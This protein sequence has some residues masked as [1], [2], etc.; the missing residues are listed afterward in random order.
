MRAPTLHRLPSPALW[1]PL[2][3]CIPRVAPGTPNPKQQPGA[4]LPG[5]IASPHRSDP[6]APPC[7]PSWPLSRTRLAG[8]GG[9]VWPR[10]L[11]NWGWSVGLGPPPLPPHLTPFPD[12]PPLCSEFVAVE[13]AT[14]LVGGAGIFSREIKQS[15]SV[16]AGWLWGRAEGPC[17]S[18]CH[19]HGRTILGSLSEPPGTPPPPF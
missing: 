17:L 3:P 9:Q 11:V 18:T 15:G 4:H 19:T 1:F 12:P 7:S 13:E 16:A 14:G 8:V 10:R 5:P 6:H 2:K